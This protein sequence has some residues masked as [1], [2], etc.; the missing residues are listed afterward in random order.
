MKTML[1]FSRAHNVS[2][3]IQFGEASVIEL[4][5]PLPARLEGTRGS[6]GHVDS[7]ECNDADCL[8]NLLILLCCHQSYW[9]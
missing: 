7:K 9:V 1:I 3:G 8:C 4:T 6:R 5:I 2:E